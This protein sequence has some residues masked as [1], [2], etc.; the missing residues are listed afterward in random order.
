MSC[1]LALARESSIFL[2]FLGERYGWVPPP[3]E[4]GRDGASITQLEMEEG[5]L[6]K[7]DGAR[8]TAFFYF[9]SPQ[10]VAELPWSEREKFTTE[11]RRDRERLAALKERILGSGLEVMTDYPAVWRGAGAQWVVGGLEELGQ[12]LVSQV[13]GAVQRLAPRRE[14]GGMEREVQGQEGYR[15][16]EGRAWVGRE[17]LVTSAL[18]TIGQGPGVVSLSCPQGA[19]TTALLS[20]LGHTLARKGARVVSFILEATL[21]PQPTLAYVLSYLLHFLGAQ[22]GGPSDM[23]SLGARLKQALQQFCTSGAGLVIILDDL[24]H[25]EDWQ[26]G[27][28]PSVLPQGA[29]LVMRALKGSKLQLLLRAR[30]DTKEVTVLPLETKERTVV[31]RA[32][33]ARQGKQLSEEVWAPH[34]QQLV[35]RRGASSPGYLSLALSK[36]GREARHEGL[37]GAVL[38]LASTTPSLLWDMLRE[39]EGACGE[40]L[41]QGVLLFCSL[42]PGGLTRPQL[43]TLLT[44]KALTESA[45]GA[46]RRGVEVLF[47]L[48]EEAGKSSATGSLGLGSLCV[49]LERLQDFLVQAGSRM[50]LVAGNPEAVVQERVV[51][52]LLPAELQRAHRL[53][54]CVTLGKW[55]E[56]LADRAA[57][58]ALPLHLGAAREEALLRETLCTPA[59]LQ[60]KVRAGLGGSLLSDLQGDSLNLRS[61]REKFW[62][63][64][65]VAEYRAFV[66]RHLEALTSS[67]SLVPQLLLNQPP[68]SRIRAAF[69]KQGWTGA[70]L[71]QCCSGPQSLEE[72][73]QESRVV[74]ETRMNPATCLASSKQ[75][76]VTGFTDGAIVVA[77]MKTHQDLFCLVGHSDSITGLGFLSDTR[78]VSASRD[79]WLSL[80]DLEKQIRVKSSRYKTLDILVGFWCNNMSKLLLCR[81]FD[82]KV[83]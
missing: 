59:F 22:T 55:R 53:L 16:R 17:E 75:H 15:E 31:A 27:W 56:G 36:L 34:L 38:G 13:W 80:W 69:L 37:G 29:V 76:L 50:Q 12:R 63:D 48:L 6:E 42:A 71:L 14:G 4:G 23:G 41:V 45:A 33:L 39:A 79:G 18:A 58:L 66:A 74:R 28:L 1:C 25:L 49:C 32:L 72:A 35:A 62:K 24:Q 9:R 26:A 20:R 8:G 61:A 70:P 11:D 2:G 60:A 64:P 19:G 30:G 47:G 67:P 77:D 21:H 78:L 44:L 7:G 43:L 5:A 83:I 68:D 10:L 82:F 57:L 52:P 46:E 51:K 73:E 54:A 3:Q 81:F 65:L 40:E